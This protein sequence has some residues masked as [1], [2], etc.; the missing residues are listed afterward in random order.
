M[1]RKEDYVKEA[2]QQLKNQSY[3]KKLDV[4]P[5][6]QYASEIRSFIKSM[7][8]RG[9]INKKMKKLPNPLPPE[10]SEIL[11]VPFT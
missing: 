1:L 5:T 6:P 7:L 9:Q 11:H 10:D 8:T 3:Y 4:D 2:D